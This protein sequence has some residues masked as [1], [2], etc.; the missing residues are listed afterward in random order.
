[1]KIAY[2]TSS[3]QDEAEKIAKT[4]LKK[5]LAAC[6][7]IVPNV[8][9][10]YWWEGMIQKDSEYLL[11]AKTQEEHIE[12]LVNEVKAIHNY[13]CPCILIFPIDGGNTDYLTWLKTQI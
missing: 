9:S 7:N 4:L 13:E 11:F 5:R 2:I 3:N 8:S 10:M 12:A 1:M 6:I